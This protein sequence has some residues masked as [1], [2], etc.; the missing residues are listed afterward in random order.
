MGFLKETLEE[1]VGDEAAEKGSDYSGKGE[2]VTEDTDDAGYH[3]APC[4]EAT[5]GD[6]EK[7]KDC[8]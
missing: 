2:P 3:K 6:S 4:D 7:K 1:H 5:D 8:H